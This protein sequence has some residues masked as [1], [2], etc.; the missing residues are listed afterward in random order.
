[1]TVLKSDSHFARAITLLAL[2]A[3]SGTALAQIAAPRTLPEL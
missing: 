2:A 1:M 3:L